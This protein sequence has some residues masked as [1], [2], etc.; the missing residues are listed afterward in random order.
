MGLHAIAAFTAKRKQVSAYGAP[1]QIMGVP[2]LLQDC[3]N[4]S[5]STAVFRLKEHSPFTHPSHCSQRLS[6][7]LLLVKEFLGGLLEG[8]LY[9]DDPEISESCQQLQF[10]QYPRCASQQPGCISMKQRLSHV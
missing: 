7:K 8:I 3:V 5:H 9:K 1:L 2:E 6:G 10:Q 4:L